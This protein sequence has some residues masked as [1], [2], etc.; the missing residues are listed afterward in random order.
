MHLTGPLSCGRRSRALTRLS[1][2]APAQRGSHRVCLAPARARTRPLREA[3]D[4]PGQATDVAPP[5]TI[6]T[7]VHAWAILGSNQ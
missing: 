7:G 1:G 5:T 2:C 4:A 6:I 3:R